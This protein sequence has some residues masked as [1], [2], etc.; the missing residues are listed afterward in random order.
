[1][2]AVFRSLHMKLMLILLLLITSLMAVVGA[3]LTTSVSSFYID[4]FY[5]QISAVFSDDSDGYV[6]TLRARA[7]EPD[8]AAGIKEMLEGRA[9][10]LGIDYRTRN[11][12]ILD[13]QSGTYLDG[14][15]EASEL[16]REQTANL[17]TARNAVAQGDSTLVGDRSDIT[18]DYMDAAIPIMGGGNAYI[19]YILDN[20][21]TVTDL[22]SQLFLIIMQALVI[23]LLISVL[24]SFLLSKTMVGPIEKLTAGAERVAAG[25][26]DSQL[27]VEST[28]EIGILTGTFNE[29]AD[30]L[31]ATLAA[32]ENERNKLDTLF[33]HMTD[34]VVAFDHDSLLIHCNP[35]ATNMLHRSV[36]EGTTY[37]TLF[38]QVYPFQET[39][40]LQ[41]PNYAEA[42]MEV[43]DRTLELFLAPFSDQ[44][45]GGVLVV[46]HDVTEQHRNEERRKEFVANVS[47]E[48]RTPL[49]NVRS[50][51]ETI[52]EAGDDL[53]RETEN[54]FL[55]V[56]IS[57]TDRMTHIVQDLLTLSRLDSG[58]SEM[59]MA[60]FPFSAAIDSVLR[61]TELEARRHKHELT[62]DYTENLPLIM[63]D[64]GRIEQVMLNVLSNAVK[65]TPD[66]GHIRVTA[67][68]E[69]ETV[70]M[71]VAD[72][73]IGIPEA[74]RSRIFE[75]FY[76][77]DKAR[78]RESGGT[79]LGLSIATEIV[80]RHH[81]S[82]TLVDRPGPGTT[83]RLE[84]P[85]TQPIGG[86]DSHE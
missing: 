40:A 15:A 49:T 61:S 32:V 76:R 75:R 28:D 48:L 17:L 18:A 83:V 52:R 21:D 50:Y 5:E 44:A 64:R 36:P 62:H 3:F 2:F 26:F 1:M 81:G 8:G 10:S 33:L 59:N 38:G 67:G 55:D 30:V 25:D 6:S 24:L 11:Y 20:K 79:G 56:V 74:D 34:G 47:H 51:A 45:S 42:E 71:E 19:I 41:R 12:F 73:G 58:R 13:G 57:E 68:S 86:E 80:Q 77:V 9:G 43:G 53:S 72:D 35:A 63:G 31:Q 22:N 14:S 54:D 70:W 65:Y 37:D 29:M 23:G 46:L 16:P 66:G 82:L 84:L 39:L 69:G 7:A 85:I 78:S 60:R 4:T 27:P